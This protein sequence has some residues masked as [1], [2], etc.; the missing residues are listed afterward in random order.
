MVE[1]YATCQLFKDLECKVNVTVINILCWFLSNLHTRTLEISVFYS[2]S[3]V[4]V[5][6]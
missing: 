5:P 6:L 3:I 1:P 4:K 2:I